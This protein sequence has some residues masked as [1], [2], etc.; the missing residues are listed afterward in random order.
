MAAVKKQLYDV[1]VAGQGYVLAGDPLRPAIKV[2]QQPVFGNRFAQGDRDIND[3]SFWWF[4]AQRDFSG[5]LKAFNL[6]ADDAK[7]RYGEAVDTFSEQ[8]VV[9]VLN[10]QTV[11][12]AFSSVDFLQIDSAAYGTL[13]A[14]VTGLIGLRGQTAPSIT[15]SAIFATTDGTTYTNVTAAGMATD[16]RPI[17]GIRKSPTGV[18]VIVTG[19]NGTYAFGTYNGSSHADITATVE[20]SET[21]GANGS[22]QG[23]EVVGQTLFTFHRNNGRELILQ[24]T[25]D[26][27]TFTKQL[28]IPGGFYK[29]SCERDGKLLYV[30]AVATSVI[31]LHEYDIVADTDTLVFTWKGPTLN[32]LIGA[33]NG[34]A[35]GTCI[36]T[37]DGKN[38]YIIFDS[39]EVWKYDGSSLEKVFTDSAGVV[40]TSLG[41]GFVKH[42]GSLYAPNLTIAFDG[43]IHPG[44]RYLT[45]SSLAQALPLISM[46]FPA[47]TDTVLFSS[48]NSSASAKT[49]LYRQTL[50]N[51]IGLLTTS[52]HDGGVSGIDKLYRSVIIE[53]DAF[54]T[55]GQAINLYYSTDGGTSFVALGTAS[56]SGDGAISRKEFFFDDD[57]ISKTMVLRF[58]I[59]NATNVATAS[60]V[61][62]SFACRFLPV[63]DYRLR[64]DLT[65]NCSDRMTLKDGKTQESKT[66]EEL[67]NILRQAWW[68]KE[69][70]ALE[71]IDASAFTLQADMTKSD[72]TLTLNQVTSNLPEQG[73]VRIGD[74]E[75]LYVGK[76][77]TQLLNLVRAARGSAAA[78]HTAGDS[79]TNAYKAVITDYQE[80]L[81]VANRVPDREYRVT[82]Q[83]LEA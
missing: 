60:P 37:N 39:G 46:R 10:G 78:T 51:Q 53:F 28:E 54:T 71:D 58:E 35:S 55:S 31:E 8:G 36:A 24:S 48:N 79:V 34:A 15:K 65:L 50:G 68:T 61:F 69:V 62:R 73:R 44:Y 42:E 70:I 64:F 67:R 5:G 75:I 23:V 29:G 40:G 41:F 13:I 20:G 14:N 45:S 17:L 76:T 22:A 30:V 57:L 38:A 1:A 3:L 27:T 4:W 47:D 25:T 80:Q 49:T 16:G 26:L 7:F 43:T 59:V 2:S 52:K 9:K 66:G 6:W 21:M 82:L 12:E 18:M 72:T 77:Q 63:P 74:E 81:I 11:E 19:S 32:N 56:Q 33:T 83:L